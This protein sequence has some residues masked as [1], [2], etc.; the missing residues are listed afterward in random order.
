[1][2]Q[3]LWMSYA[4]EVTAAIGDLVQAG[5]DGSGIYV[6]AGPKG[7][8]RLEATGRHHGLLGRLYRFIEHLGDE[9]EELIAAS[10]H[11]NAW[12]LVLLVPADDENKEAAARILKGH[13]GHRVVHFGKGHWE[14][15]G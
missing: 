14:S 4:D 15:L 7:A 10:E 2:R 1:M 5:F 3:G 8:E 11:L 13:G 12:G 9:H 6:L